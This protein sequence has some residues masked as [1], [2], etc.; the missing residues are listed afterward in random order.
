MGWRRAFHS[1]VSGPS[2]APLAE[3]SVDEGRLL[4]RL[5]CLYDRRRCGL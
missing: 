4:F 3:S 2:L 1:A 5:E